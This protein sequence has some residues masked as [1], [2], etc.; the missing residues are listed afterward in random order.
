MK[1]RIDRELCKGAAACV[2]IAGKTFQLDTF[3]KAV[4]IDVHGDDEATIWK[5][6]EACPFDAVILEDEET[7]EWLYP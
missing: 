1:I 7:G 3:D 6:A 2:V 5:A 4:V